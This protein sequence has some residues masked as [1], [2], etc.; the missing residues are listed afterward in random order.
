MKAGWK[1]KRLGELCDVDAGQSPEGRFYNSEG[2][3]MPFYQGK[4]DFGEMFVKQASTW[5]TEITK[6]ARE[7]D[8]LMSVRAPVGPINF[9]TE[10]ICIGRGLASIRAGTEIDRHFLF[11]QLLHLQPAISGKEGAVFASINKSEIGALDLILPPL[12]EQKRIVAL[13][14]EAFARIDEAKTKAEANL[15]KAKS[16]FESYLECTFEKYSKS[17]GERPLEDV[18]VK[19]ETVDPTRSP[20]V[21][22]D[23]IDVSSV[24][25]ETLS[26]QETQ[27]L[28]GKDAPSRARKAVKTNDVIFATIRPTLRRIA[29]VPEELND[30][31]CSTGYI[32]L[33]TKADFDHRWVFYFLQTRSFMVAMEAL[34][35]G[36]S[37]PAVTDND[38]RSQAIP[39]AALKDQSTATDNLDKLR[40]EISQLT[41]LYNNKI[42]LLIELQESLLAQAF[43]GELTP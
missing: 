7:G 37:Y 34:Q 33:R 28:L 36:A 29:I 11:Y 4:K 21:E 20:N 8:I 13:L 24:S 30:Q 27:K 2:V 10:E 22:F 31:V 6:T 16:V 39:A 25:K 43:A 42:S 38:V 9:A 5:T 15:E 19:S 23:Y 40:S 12:A 32:V 1:T 17:C 35:K 41:L 18:L 3:G 26:I 14:D